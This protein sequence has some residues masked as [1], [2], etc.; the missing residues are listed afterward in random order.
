MFFF[1]MVKHF[2]TKFSFL[3]ITKYSPYPVVS[4]YV[5][6]IFWIPCIHAENVFYPFDSV[7]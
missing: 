3:Y 2:T 4:F 7:A 1:I 6:L 5:Y